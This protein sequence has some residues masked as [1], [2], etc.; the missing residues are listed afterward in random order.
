M[1]ACDK[2]V[3]VFDVV[4]GGLPDTMP[5]CQCSLLVRAFSVFR[6]SCVACDPKNLPAKTKLSQYYMVDGERCININV[7]GMTITERIE[8]AHK[9]VADIKNAAQNCKYNKSR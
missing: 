5:C 3:T 8:L 4:Y 7:R 2:I 6:Q 1:K 9:A